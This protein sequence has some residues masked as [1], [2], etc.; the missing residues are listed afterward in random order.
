MN[1]DENEE[2]I[3]FEKLKKEY[4]QLK[5]EFACLISPDKSHEIL[6][7][8]ISCQNHH[9]HP[10]VECKMNYICDICNKHEDNAKTYYCTNCDF[11][12][13]LICM[14]RLGDQNLIGYKD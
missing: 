14:K 7:I 6:P 8:H 10:F 12:C 4:Q 11:N 9:P 5:N 3:K 1:Q 2:M 13:C